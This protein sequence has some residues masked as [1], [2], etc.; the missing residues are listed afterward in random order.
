M[1]LFADALDARRDL[2]LAFT[3]HALSRIHEISPAPAL[4]YAVG[5]DEHTLTREELT[6]IQRY[7]QDGGVILFE[8]AGGRGRFAHAAEKQL[9]AAFGRLARPLVQDSIITGEFSP[10]AINCSTLDYRPYSLQVLG[11][12]D[13][14][15]RLR[16]IVIDGSPRLLFSRE[17]I[18]NA[19][20][21]QP[22]WGVHGYSPRSAQRL[23]RNVLLYVIE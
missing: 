11:G 18:S 15:P 22:V 23:L 9:A 21:D 20:L 14:T 7:V 13:T 16:G 2:Q 3:S 19:L 12:I 4:V 6:A 8:T 17:D 1:D 5:T 10:H